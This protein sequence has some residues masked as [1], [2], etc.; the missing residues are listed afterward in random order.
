M[1]GR[2]QAVSRSIP[3]VWRCP[4]E[5]PGGGRSALFATV[6]DARAGPLEKIGVNLVGSLFCDLGCEVAG[7]VPMRFWRIDSRWEPVVRIPRWSV[8]FA[9]LFVPLAAV[10]FVVVSFVVEN[11]D[12]FSISAFLAM[13]LIG[14]PMVARER[15]VG[16]YRAGDR[17]FVVNYFGSDELSGAD[18]VAINPPVAVVGP[19]R[20]V[21]GGS[22]R[23]VPVSVAARWSRRREE[24]RVRLQN[25]IDLA[26]RS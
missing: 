25:A 18:V 4:N 14:L 9:T 10:S 16:V 15:I 8:V 11:R 24:C 5:D 21:V 12:R 17:I 7:D 19:L 26:R 13:L 20:L 1:G 2:G 6:C 3:L 23:P 22:E